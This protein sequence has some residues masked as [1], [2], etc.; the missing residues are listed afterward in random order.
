MHASAKMKTHFHMFFKRLIILLSFAIGLGGISQSALSQNTQADSLDLEAGPFTLTQAIQVAL[1]NNIDIQRAVMSIKNADQEVRVAWSELYPEVTASADYTR[2]LEVPVNFLP[3]VVFNPD[4]DPNNL[5]PVA[6]GTDNN[7]TG[8]VSVSQKIFDGQA[9]VGVNSSELF[10]TVQAESLRATAQQV[11]TQTRLDYYQVLIAKE[12][13]RLQQVQID[14]IEDNLDDARAQF[15]QGLVDNYAVLQLEVQLGNLRP[16]LTQSKFAVDEARRGLLNT[17]GLPLRLPV[18]VQGNLN[19]FQIRGRSAGVQ[20]NQSL[21][22]VD[23]LT[24]LRL[25][26]DSMLT[27]RAQN[28]RGDLRVLDLQQQLQQKQI[29]ANQSQY[30]PTLTASYNL[31]YNAAQP[32]TPIFFGTE[33]QRARAQTVMLSLNFPLFQGFRRSAVVQQSKIQLKDLE[34]LKYQTMQNAR[35]EITTA[36]E[37]I[38]EAYETSTAREKALEQAQTG[39]D[40]SLLRYQN[41]L[42]SQQEVTDADVQLRE[43]ELNYAQMVFNYLS[44]KARYDLSVGM[45]PY[46]DE[47]PEAVRNDITK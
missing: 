17:I 32:G 33:D 10:K 21:K 42:G 30:L 23:N 13:V 16:Q 47:E 38:R 34:L 2:N 20:E 19:L 9:F 5:V 26:A 7:W 25:Q 27:G 4:G 29:R 18:R 45:V 3:E 24:P 46:I 12:Q 14:R 15:R 8:G 6:F 43:A 44:A 1:A 35:N 40:R 11:I 37:N 39:Y 22:K 31:Q 28:M 41:G 36:E